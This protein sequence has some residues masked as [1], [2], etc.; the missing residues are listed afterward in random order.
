MATKAK[1]KQVP[2]GTL[3]QDPNNARG[4]SKRNVDLIATSIGKV[5]PARPIVVDEDGVILAG[6]ATQQAALQQG[7][8]SANVVDVDGETV[9]AVRVT[10]LSPTEKAFLALSDNRA[11]ELA[12]WKPTA[13]K[14]LMDAGYQDEVNQV[15]YPQELDALMATSAETAAAVAPSN[16]MPAMALIRGATA[17]FGLRW[18]G[19]TAAMTEEQAKRLGAL[20]SAWMTSHGSWEGLVRAILDTAMAELITTIPTTN[21]TT[22][23]TT[24]AEEFDT[25]L[26]LSAVA[27]TE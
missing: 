11:A 13:I 18:A 16:E 17:Q 4:H 20:F 1:S 9:V 5:G 10:G 26:D 25:P 8:E 12:V 24:E 14:A 23:V 19:W 15:W 21:A 2:L 22:D 6:N 7:L 27:A 3:H